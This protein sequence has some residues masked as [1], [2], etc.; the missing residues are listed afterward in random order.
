MKATLA[1]LASTVFLTAFA[2]MAEPPAPNP[3]FSPYNTP[4]GVPAFDK[5]KPEHFEPAIDEGM[6]Q[7]DAEVAAIVAKTGAPT[8]VNTIEALEG[9]GDLLRRVNTVFGN[10]NSANTNDELQKIAQT[11]APKLSKHS[12]DISLNSA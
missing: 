9:S 5:I 1:F 12:D 3:F 8:F 6:K 2:P 11:V 4:F 7:Q 10:L